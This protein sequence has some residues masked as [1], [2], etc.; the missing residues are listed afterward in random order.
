MFSPICC[1]IYPAKMLYA[2]W[3]LGPLLNWHVGL[4]HLQ[5][6]VCVCVYI[7][8][9]IYIYTNT[10]T[11]IHMYVYTTYTY[12]YIYIYIYICTYYGGFRHVYAHTFICRHACCI[13]IVHIS[14]YIERCTSVSLLFMC[15]PIS[16]R[17]TKP[18]WECSYMLASELK[19]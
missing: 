16:C 11:Y 15:V 8:M 17:L 4:V 10:N 6:H 7:Y 3:L 1:V 9:C 13:F 12:L 5:I 18:P 14:T 2:P 19:L